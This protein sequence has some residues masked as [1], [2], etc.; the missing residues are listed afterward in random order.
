MLSI[1]LIKANPDTS[2]LRFA[3]E[4]G[5]SNISFPISKDINMTLESAD[6][7]FSSA[8]DIVAT[9]VFDLWD[10]TEQGTKVSQ[11]VAHHCN[12]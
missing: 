12:V 6:I 5:N 8:K 3:A 1:L 7:L 9:S 2:T 4:G 11:A 10:G